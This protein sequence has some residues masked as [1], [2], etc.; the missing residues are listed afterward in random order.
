L[1]IS[2]T[3]KIY[4]LLSLFLASSKTAVTQPACNCQTKPGEKVVPLYICCAKL[5]ADGKP[6]NPKIQK[7]F[8]NI[9][10]KR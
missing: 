3:I 10:N 2:R 1:K 4:N 9:G 8:P 7:M 6:V 5:G